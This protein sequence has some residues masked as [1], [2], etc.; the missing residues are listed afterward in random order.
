M[1]VAHPKAVWR[2]NACR[3]TH[4]DEDDARECCQPS[5]TEGYEC[6]VCGEFHA[7]EAEAIACHDWD[8]ERTIPPSAAELEA[9]GQLRLPL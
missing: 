2:C 5:I 6:P 3:F 9:A 8:P 4:D 1:T 7:E